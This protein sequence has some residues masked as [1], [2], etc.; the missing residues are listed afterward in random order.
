MAL[1]RDQIFKVADELD[2][3]AIKPTLSNVRKRLGSGSYT[4][5]QEAMAEWKSRRQQAST[6]SREPAPAELAERTSELA[7]EI[8]T[9]ARAAADLALTGERQQME[10]EQAELRSQA[11]EAVELADA[12]TLENDQ[13]KAELAELHELRA[14]HE[15]LTAELADVKRKTGE[16]INRTMEKANRKDTEAIEARKGEKAAIERAARAEGKVEALQ[17]QLAEMTAALKGGRTTG[18]RS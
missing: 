12:L 14:A 10:A 18:G 2:A 13:L 5:I 15:R 8:W 6:P 9:M 16:E 11:A 3:E 1:T 17:G 4:T 7:G